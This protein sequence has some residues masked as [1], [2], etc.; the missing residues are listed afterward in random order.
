MS[1]SYLK[2][3]CCNHFLNYL[4]SLNFRNFEV[5]DTFYECEH[6]VKDHE[7]VAIKCHVRKFNFSHGFER[8]YY[9]STCCYCKSEH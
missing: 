3:L 1:R 6:S 8:N 5:N 4:D 7:N 9:A 2:I